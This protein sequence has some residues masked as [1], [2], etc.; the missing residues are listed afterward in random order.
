MPKAPDKRAFGAAVK[1]LNAAHRGGARGARRASSRAAE[2]AAAPRAA[3]VDVTLPGRR[4]AHRLAPSGHPGDARDRGDLPRPRLQRRRGSGDRERPLQLRAA[5]LPRRPSGP[6]RAGHPVRRGRPAAAHAHLA[7]ADPHHARAQA[8]DPRHLP[9]A[10]LPQRQRPAPLAD[11]PPGRGA[12]RRRGRSRW[13]T[14][15]GRSRRSCTRLFAPTTGVRLRPSYFPFTE[16]SCEVDITCQI[17]GGERLP[18]LLGHRLDGD[19]RRRHG[20][21]ARARE[22]RHRSRPLL[23]LRLRA[24][25]RPGGDEPVGHP[26]HPRRCSRA[27]SGCCA[28]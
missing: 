7:G 13:A 10:R 16:P 2:E 11:V 3:R 4:P 9:G 5:Q 27:T 21:P 20:R 15:R 23:R 22:L 18:D 26:Q 14:S 28:R 25:S 24:R 12:L 8:A 17:C 19:P 6:R 1:L